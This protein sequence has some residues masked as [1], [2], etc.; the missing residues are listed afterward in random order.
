MLNNKTLGLL[1]NIYYEYIIN[2][3]KLHAEL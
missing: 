2:F 3:Y 1:G